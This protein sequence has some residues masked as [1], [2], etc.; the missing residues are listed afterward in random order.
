MRELTVSE[1]GQVNG[2]GDVVDAIEGAIGGGAA[3]A[4]VAFV[5][6][7][8]N[9]VTIGIMVVGALAGAAIEYFND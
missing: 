6:S 8:S 1:I 4:T 2:G 3:G 5:L 7:T 9:P